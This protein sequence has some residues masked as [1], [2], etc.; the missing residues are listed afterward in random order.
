MEGKDLNMREFMRGLLD[1]VQMRG[2]FEKVNQMKLQRERRE[3][4]GRS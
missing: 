2:V 4:K 1:A 3:E